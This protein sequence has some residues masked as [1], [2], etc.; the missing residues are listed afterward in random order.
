MFGEL[1]RKYQ[2]P[3]RALLLHGILTS[4]MVMIGDISGLLLFNGI[5]EW[6][7]YLVRLTFILV[8][9]Y[10]VDDCFGGCHIEDTGTKVEKVCVVISASLTVDLIKYS[11]WRRLYSVLRL[12]L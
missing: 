3:L 6:S 8:L 9:T 5:I 11:S 4:L 2:T 10:T 12:Y 7:W 1:H